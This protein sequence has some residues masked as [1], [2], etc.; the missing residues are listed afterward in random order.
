MPSTIYDVRLRYTL[1]DR[2]GAGVDNI[3]KATTRAAG[4]VNLL[5]GA[6]GR[7][8]A[9]VAGG[10]GIQA[11]AKALVGFNATVEDT[12]LQIGGMLALSKNTDLSAELTRADRLYMN[13]Q[14]RAALLPGTT[15]EYARM[16][17][18]VTQP[19]VD[20]GMSM[21]DLEDLTVTATVAAKA[22]GEQ[23]DVAARDISQ[24]LRGQFHSTD[25]FAGKVLGAIGYKGEE[26]RERFN[27]L[28]QEERATELRR[29]LTM[30]QW[31]Q[32]A[33]AQ[34][35][36][37][38]GV[39]ST[40]KDTMEQLLAKVGAPLFQ[41]ITAELKEWNTWSEANADKISAWAKDFGTT[42]VDG[43]RLLKDAIGFIV[44]HKDDLILIAKMWLAASMANSVGGML[45]GAGGG[46]AGAFTKD[47]YTMGQKAG[48]GIGGIARGA[49]AD[50]KGIG[51]AIL[52]N[53][54]VVAAAG[55][56]GW[57]VGRKIDEATGI[58]KILMEPIARLAG[59]WDDAAEAQ[60]RKMAEINR[61]MDELD[62]AI[63][64]RA[65]QARDSKVAG[66]RGT[67]TFTNMLAS[68]DV[69][70]LEIDRLRNDMNP[71]LRMAKMA[72]DN[73][74]SD[75]V[76]PE[77]LQELDD[78]TAKE[79]G[80]RDRQVVTQVRANVAATQTDMAMAIA[81]S[82]LTDAQRKNV[83][84][85]QTTQ[86]VMAEMV[87]SMTMARPTFFGFGDASPRMLSPDEVLNIIRT[88]NGIEPGKPGGNQKA[89]G[90]VNVTIQRIEVKSEDP[91]RFAFGLVEAFRDVT[92]NPSGAAAAIREG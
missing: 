48:P 5:G 10:F 56:F 83:D 42:L 16:M 79:R 70:E 29:A 77:L 72:R 52:G 44:E 88:A 18:M 64:K 25:P 7:L 47:L 74:A 28:S 71:T 33:A 57:E 65:K 40:F 26:G 31:V 69:K 32:L 81:M 23:A 35:Q 15:Q 30:K 22:L 59:V 37:F 24:V 6:F 9:V 63:A 75:I 67:S 86:K 4:G 55:M 90:K 12:K 68:S 13:I 3:G 34:G 41:A 49:L 78:R 11:A 36:T 84:E 61:S 87:K 92:K 80:L 51:G 20:A 14:K 91:D 76:N 45:G 21:K 54:G 85:L 38:N 39:L 17:G 62:A 58:G 73:G 2:A 66:A 46:V 82:K 8:A 50:A 1:D 43:F 60:D 53:A 19:L 27:A 89:P